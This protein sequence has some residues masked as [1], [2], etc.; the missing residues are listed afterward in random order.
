MN[1][2]DYIKYKIHKR[3]LYRITILKEVLAYL[4]D[5]L[6][7]Y[8]NIH[9]YKEYHL[10]ILLYNRLDYYLNLK[11]K[12]PSGYIVS[13]YFALFEPPKKSKAYQLYRQNC[14]EGYTCDWWK[15][16]NRHKITVRIN[17]IK[18]LIKD[19]EGDYANLYEIDD[20]YKMVEHGRNKCNG[21]NGHE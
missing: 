2:K 12:E 11:Y 21:I 14:I 7:N 4:E 10:C 8:D 15:V 9:Y 1:L 6:K 5:Y 16:K 19:Y 18:N 13:K 17:Y 3:P 20:I